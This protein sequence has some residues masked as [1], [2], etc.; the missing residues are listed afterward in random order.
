MATVGWVSSGNFCYYGSNP[1]E[2]AGGLDAR[3]LVQFIP[4]A[5]VFII[6][7]ALYSFLFNFLRRPDTIQLSS[8]FVSGGMSSDA[9][10]VN[11]GR[12]LRK[13]G[14][15]RDPKASA[16][17]R[18]EP[19]NPD[20]PW[21]QLEF[22]QVG[23]RQWGLTPVSSP[24]PAPM[25]H[26]NTGDYEDSLSPSPVDSAASTQDPK[27]ATTPLS[28]VSTSSSEAITP[29]GCTSQR[30]SESET[31]VTP[32]YK[33]VDGDRSSPESELQKGIL[34]APP[35]FTRTQHV[36]RLNREQL[37]EEED[38]VE[39]QEIVPSDDRRASGQT[40][41]EFF[42]E[43]QAPGLGAEEEGGRTFGTD[44]NGKV[45]ISATAYFNRQASLLMLYFPLAVSFTFPVRV[46]ANYSTWLCS[47]FRS[48][49][50]Y[51]PWCIN[52]RAQ[53]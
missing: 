19:V 33:Y 16:V 39:D 36:H 10:G 28:R 52:S 13:F 53:L 25:K 14:G 17:R 6:I 38:D 15:A 2:S 11:M 49:D 40:L 26:F 7:C 8:Q 34:L 41:K 46:G 23:G 45:P 1:I 35:V 31:L 42:Q 48:S 29:L 51:T 50:S 24:T 3:D 47:A 20:A 5:M 12:V 37:D 21:E 22:V 44:T 18:N 4:R 43:H 27:T 32:E 9:K 30:P